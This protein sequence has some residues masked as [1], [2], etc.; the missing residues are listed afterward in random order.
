MHVAPST[1]CPL[2]MVIPLN[3]YLGCGCPIDS[4]PSDKINL[5]MYFCSVQRSSSLEGGGGGGDIVSIK[6][7]L[8]VGSILP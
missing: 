2:G 4:L 5:L 8:H 7:N 6:A 1:I 3:L